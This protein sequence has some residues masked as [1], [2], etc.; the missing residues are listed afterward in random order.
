MM[1]RRIMLWLVVLIALTAARSAPPA[2][3]L[4]D[5]PVKLVKQGET[6]LKEGRYEQALAC[7]EAAAQIYKEAGKRPEEVNVRIRIVMALFFQ[8]HYP[9]ALRVARQTAEVANN[10]SYPLGEGICLKWIGDIKKRQAKL[11]EALEAYNEAQAALK[12]AREQQPELDAGDEIAVI[13]GRGNTSFELGRYR[14]AVQVYEEVLS[15][16]DDDSMRLAHRD[17]LKAQTLRD[18]AIVLMR[19]A[20]SEEALEKSE[21][22][23]DIFQTLQDSANIARMFTAIGGIYEDL[24]ERKRNPTYYLNSRQAYEAA[25]KIQEKADLDRD[26]VI[27]LNNIGTVLDRWGWDERLPPLHKQALASYLKALATLREND[28]DAKDLE[29][30]ILNHIG[31]AHIH[32]SVYENSPQQHLE[33]ALYALKHALEIQQGINDQTQMW[34][35]LSNLGWRSMLRE[36]VETAREYLQQAVKLFEESVQQAGIDAFEISLR[37]QADAAY[38]RLL[39]LLIA[40]GRFEA[41]FDVSEQARARVFLDQLGKAEIACAPGQKVQQLEKELAEIGEQ[42][43]EQ[44]KLPQ[45]RISQLEQDRKDKRDDLL[46][47]KELSCPDTSVTPRKLNAVRTELQALGSDV[48]LLSYFVTPEQTMAFIL[49]EDA[50]HA[51]ALPVRRETL[52]AAVTTFHER[53]EPPAPHPESLQT[54]YRHLIAPVK[55]YLPDTGRVG[56]IPHDLLHYV[57]FAA[58]SDGQRYVSEQYALFALPSASALEFV[59]AKRKTGRPNILA[60]A[61]AHAQGGAP[62]PFAAAEVEAI[63]REHEKST[64]L[65]SDAE[66]AEATETNFKELAPRCRIVHLAAHAQLDAQ[67]PLSSGIYLSPDEKE[68]GKLEVYEM[69]DLRLTNADMVVLSACETNAGQRSRGDDIIGLTRAVIYAGTASVVSTLWKVNDFAAKELMS[70]FYKHLKHHSKAEALRAA[71]QDIRRKFPH[72]RYWAGFVLT[73]DPGAAPTHLW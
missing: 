9:E 73:G 5:A 3:A 50:F 23:L 72:P 7:F 52:Q 40:D 45:E 35:T 42:L 46:L 58:L 4:S 22:A 14:Q 29:A 38:Q 54:L 15:K 20:Q 61:N 17:H 63:V 37:E 30:T 26:Q 64:V 2:A 56:I 53:L 1:T 67:D 16:F 62:L 59:L 11:S 6:A 31:E 60:M 71:Q 51:L 57:P 12:T 66:K 68:D 55:A 47:A 19:L 39:L 49:R 69:Y 25:L 36:D 32:L 44:D 10:I 8:H 43:G 18:Y 13:M 33:Q 21:Q 24:G 70:A 27:T 28:I 65:I 41:A 34:L 48:A